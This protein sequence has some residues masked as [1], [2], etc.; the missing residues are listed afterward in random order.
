VSLTLPE[1]EQ[2]EDTDN[3]NQKMQIREINNARSRVRSVR[4]NAHEQIN[5][6]PP[7]QS[8]AVRDRGCRVYLEVVKSYAMELA[9][10]IRNKTPELWS[11]DELLDV[12]INHKP[13]RQKDVVDI[14]P[15]TASTTVTGIRG[16]LRTEFPIKARFDVEYSDSASGSQTYH[17]IGEWTPS[18][19]EI[20]MI[21]MQIDQARQKL[22]LYLTGPDEIGVESEEAY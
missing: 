7:Q 3:L 6:A 17:E 22:N 1:A 21:V 8:A 14:N 16:L 4:N 5:S 10:L 9:P 11:E 2:I 13:K 19:S 20:D 12:E 18:F 15:I